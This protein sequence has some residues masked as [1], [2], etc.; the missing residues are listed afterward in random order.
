VL[1][2]E[3]KGKRDIY[4]K[5]CRIIVSVDINELDLL[6]PF[7]AGIIDTTNSKDPVWREIRKCKPLKE[8]LGGRI[9]H[10]FKSRNLRRMCNEFV[11][12]CKTS[13]DYLTNKTYIHEKDKERFLYI[14]DDIIGDM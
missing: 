7:S 10:E 13:P 11:A 8:L 12:N 3:E 14:A 1:K 9:N 4:V 5:L 2:V 6:S